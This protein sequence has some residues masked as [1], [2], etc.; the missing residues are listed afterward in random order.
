VPQ[1]ATSRRGNAAHGRAAGTRVRTLIVDDQ[2]VFRIGLRLYFSEAMPALGPFGEADSL[3]AALALAGSRPS[4]AMLDASLEARPTAENVS[5][6]RQAMPGC[7]VVMM[8]SAPDAT[9]VA[10]ALDAGARGVLLKTASPEM[11]LAAARAALSGETW[12]QPELSR[13]LYA[14]L[15]R[16][17]RGAE[18]VRQSGSRLTARQAEILNLIAMGLRNAE[19]AERLTISEQTVKTHVA[20]ILR[21][22]DVKS[23]LQ[24]ARVA[25]ESRLAKT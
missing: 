23:R 22:L 19:I 10:L 17:V 18:E 25:I 9:Q 4:L 20:A 7:A 3:E 14:D 24:A 13:A 6:L 2:A 15:S 21:R 8:G 5:R 12:V 1:T 11:F 16:R